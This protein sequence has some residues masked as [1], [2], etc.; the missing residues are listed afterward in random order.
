MNAVKSFFKEISEAWKSCWSVKYFKIHFLFSF[1]LFA[2]VIHFSCLFLSIWETRIGISI[3]DPL[4][5]RLTPRDFSVQIFSIVHS[6]MLITLVLFLATPK[7]FLKGLQAYAILLFF[8]TLFIYILPL[9][10]P[11]GMIF[12]QDPITA[13]FLNSVNV[14]TK[15]L[16]FSGHISAMCLFLY[17]TDNKVWKT[18]LMIATP[19]LALLILWQHVHYTIDVVAAP[20]FAFI[21]CKFIDVV[22][23]RWEFGLDNIQSEQLELSR[24]EL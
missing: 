8:R 23:E 12:L 6:S 14:V 9:E 22:N 17:F 2:A 15:D 20:F 10:A 19:M 11:R 1:I 24:N 7:K 21:C 5:S 3:I 18:Y 4:L 13:F 16:F